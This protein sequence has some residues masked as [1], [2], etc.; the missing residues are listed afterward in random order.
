MKNRVGEADVIFLTFE[1]VKKKAGC[2]QGSAEYNNAFFTFSVTEQ[3]NEIDRPFRG[4]V[5]AK[6]KVGNTHKVEIRDKDGNIKTKSIMLERRIYSSNPK[7]I[8]EKIA[9][10]IRKLYAKYAIEIQSDVFQSLRPESITPVLAVSK[11]GM[12]Y[13]SYNHR[14]ASDNSKVQYY[15]RLQRAA[16]S[17]PNI[18]MVQITATKLK[19]WIETTS[20]PK[21]QLKELQKFWDYC[22]Y[23]H[24]C[25]GENPIHIPR[26]KKSNKKGKENI[27]KVDKL[28]PEQTQALYEYIEANMTGPHMGTILAIG[29]GFKPEKIVELTWSDIIIEDDNY[30]IVRDYIP[31]RAGATKNYKRPL[32]PQA[33]R[34]VKKRYEDL[35]ENYT[36]RNL[37][38]MPVVSAKNDSTKKYNTEALKKDAQRVVVKYVSHDV[39]K[40]I[41]NEDLD[42]AAAFKILNNT[43][44]YDLAVRCSLNK[45]SGVF[46]FLT[47]KSL[48]GDTTSDS[49]RDFI[50]R[51]A[52]RHI[53]ELTLFLD[54]EV[55]ETEASIS[56]IQEDAKTVIILRPETNHCTI[57]GYIKFIVPPKS[58]CIIDSKYGVEGNLKS[59]KKSNR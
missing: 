6:D 44:M 52:L 22:L 39:L 54:K 43:Y 49:Y 25:I 7:V 48:L 31:E 19:K 56:T 29:G 2:F 16:R 40:E 1:Y 17:M 13:V 58:K 36:P 30:V 50:S 59:K 57:N 11:H 28:L 12:A 14:D 8:K 46:K 41:S 18:P 3:I 5:T 42:Y 35:L 9:D 26:A 38:K 15:G 47:R 37:S 21:S 24:I 20:I 34:I 53:H 32:M 33:A 27:V 4:S 10:A 55:V 51:A 23:K 45:E